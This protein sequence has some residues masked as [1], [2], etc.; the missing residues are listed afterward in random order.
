MTISA[1]V[2][3]HA[4]LGRTIALALFAILAAWLSAPR[5]AAGVQIDCD[6]TTD[7]CT[8]D[9]CVTQDLLEITV[10]SCTLDFGAVDLVIGKPIEVPNNGTLSLTAETIEVRRP[11]KG[12][13]LKSAAGDG[14]DVTLTSTVGDIL[15]K[16]RIDVSG[17]LSTGTILVDSAADVILQNKLR[18]QARRKGAVATGG[19]VTVQADGAVSSTKKG[20]IDVRGKKNTTGG[21][22]VNLTAQS[23]MTLAAIID[24]RGDPGGAINLLCP[25]C[26]VTAD[27]ALRVEGWTEGGG[28]VV[29]GTAASLTL[30]AV[31]ATGAAPG[32]G[33]TVSLA[34]GTVD[35]R[36][37]K[38]KGRGVP[39]GT[40]G[41]VAGTAAIVQ[42]V[43][44]SGTSGGS[45]DIASTTGSVAVEKVDGRGKGGAGATVTID[46]ATDAVVEKRVDVRGA[47]GGEF[48]ISAGGNV[49][50]GSSGGSKF[51]ATPDGIIEGLAG[52]DL[53]AIGKF[54]AGASGCI[55]LSATGVLDTS[56]ATFDVALSASCP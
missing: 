38:A 47:P 33:G 30:R 34:A 51:R 10:A 4:R 28:G 43:L 17:K 15:V 55:G 8:G 36:K 6:A 21:G 48:R 39:G 24:G 19:T 11:I 16:G 7:F 53:T 42:S 54:E 13:H 25:S 32:T 18:S 12:L 3:S 20:L 29:T 41:I 40:V 5:V 31:N 44:V 22:V 26:D 9:P 2:T 23:G 37:I 46:A 50:L 45:V 56:L 35:V 49:E 14:A 27:K 52:G 1:R